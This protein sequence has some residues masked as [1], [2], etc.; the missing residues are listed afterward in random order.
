MFHSEKTIQERLQLFHQQ[1]S[2]DTY[3]ILGSHRVGEEAIFRVWAPNAS[4]VSVVGD[5][6]GWRFDAAPMHKVTS[7]IWET[8]VLG[9][10]NFDAYKYAIWGPDGGVTLK[11][12]PYARHSQTAPQN[13]SRFYDSAG[14][15]WQDSAWQNHI[16]NWDMYCSPINIYEVHCESWRKY[17]DGANFDY[18]KLATELSQYAKSMGYT[19]VEFMPMTEYPYSGSW[20]YQVTGYFAPT[21]RYGTPDDFKKMVDVFHSAGI[22]VIL[23]WVPAHFPRDEHG[24]F[25]FD[26]TCCFE[27]DDP[28]RGEHKEWGTCVFNYGRVEVMNFLLSSACMFVKEFHVDGIRV[29]AVASMLYL[30][31]GRGYGEWHPNQHGG[32][33]HIEAIEF[34]RRLNEACHTVNPKV[35]MIAEESTAWPIVTGPADRGGLGFNFKWNM[36]W[37]NDTL[38]YQSLDPIYRKFEHNLITFSFVYAFSE[39]FILP[40][41]HDEVVHGK[42]SLINKMPGEYDQKFDNFR[43]YMTYI[44]A[45]PGKKLTFMGNEFAQFDE[46]N[47]R[48]ELDWFL[49]SYE[50]HRITLDFVKALN[51]FYL[52][53]PELFE[54]DVEFS[55]FKWISGEDHDQS[56]ISFRRIAKN[57]SELVVVCNFTPVTRE[58]YRIGVPEEGSYKVVFCSD[59]AEFGGKTEKKAKSVRS[60][61]IAMHG[62]PN[63]V[64]LTLPGLSVTVYKK[65]SRTRRNNTLS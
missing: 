18:V 56:I 19:H 11:A 25:R 47:Y 34:L 50:K 40:I 60:E 14:Y 61:K 31:Y 38:R 62:S 55:G 37:M 21:S 15:L 1:L 35:M 27:Y 64:E 63:S 44:I 13:A 57:G 16:K 39:N 33:E 42:C 58:K 43:A 41:S 5:F 4:A 30:D 7:G 2:A 22:G 36:G 3:E 51:R 32:K 48:K 20:G 45:H 28:T 65:N 17:E 29:D 8:S 23:D 24:L 10:K 54:Q 52:S 49:L 6:N 59:W 46:W 26:G 12:D 53:S 9:V